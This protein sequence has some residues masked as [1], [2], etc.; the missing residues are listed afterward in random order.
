VATVPLDPQRLHEGV[1]AVGWVRDGLVDRVYYMAY[2][3]PIDVDAVSR[4]WHTIPANQLT[5]LLQNYRMVGDRAYN[6]SGSLLIDYARLLSS[7][8]PGSSMGLYHFPHLD[9]SQV[10]A[11]SGMRSG[12]RA[13][14]LTQA[15]GETPR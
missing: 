6:H 5:V 4:A 1:D 15:K 11:L 12:A 10:E 7:R 13:E 9:E 8:W 2:G 3:T 14:A